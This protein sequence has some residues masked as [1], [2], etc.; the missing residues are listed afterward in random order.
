M[1]NQKLT[2]TIVDK[3]PFEKT[4]Q[5]LYWDKE[6]PGFGL[7]VGKTK[8]A[9]IVQ[10]AVNG[11]T[12]RHTI[13]VHGIYT[14]ETAR[15][16]AR[17]YLHTMSKQISIREE[18]KE[19]KLKHHTLQDIF[20]NYIE[21][22][23]TNISPKAIKDY[24]SFYKNYLS[25]WSTREMDNISKDE[26]VSYYKKI[27]GQGKNSTADHTFKLLKAL[28]NYAQIENENLRNPVDILSKRK[29]WSPNVRK[30]T[31]IKEHEIAQWYKAVTM[32]NNH[33][34]KD[35]LLVTL[36]TGMRKS[37]VFSMKWD[38]IDF[39]EKTLTIPHTKNK[40]P[41]TLP[42]NTHLYNILSERNK[43]AAK[44]QWVFVGNGKD[45]HISEP[46][47]VMKKI[48]EDS[49]VTFKMHDLRRTFTTIANNMDVSTH[50][51]KRL[52]NHSMASD[53]TAGYIMSDVNSLRDVSQ[54]IG[55]RIWSLA[56]DSSNAM[57][58]A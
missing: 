9:Y 40:K 4:G 6:L 21:D 10:K 15:Q 45:G 38:Y 52:I 5:K 44:S 18:K 25:V 16:E 12:E 39:K 1:L 7:R 58:S 41:L 36:F 47:N 49:G 56:Q 19:K 24:K 34:F 46:K 42:L 57:V 20:D 32:I 31:Y 11:R 43:Y 26:I 13:G 23:S 29:L 35:A 28:Y 53:V 48:A 14:P 51:I 55:D 33:S 17:N 30:T 50:S 8:K 2:K 3:I 22:R 37:E 54:K 27:I